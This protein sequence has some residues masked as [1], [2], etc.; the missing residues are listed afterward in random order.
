MAGQGRNADGLGDNPETVNVVRFPGDWFGPLEDLVPIGDDHSWDGADGRDDREAADEEYAYADGFWGEQAEAV[1]RVS[2]SFERPLPTRR[3]PRRALV[4]L[5]GIGLA[6]VAAAIVL[7]S[8]HSPGVHPPKLSRDTVALSSVRSRSAHAVSPTEKPAGRKPVHVRPAG[9][10]V[11]RR[12][13]RSP[14]PARH[15]ARGARH[16]IGT[17]AGSGTPQTQ[18]DRTEVTSTPSDRA[19]NTSATTAL[20]PSPTGLVAPP[21]NSSQP[22]S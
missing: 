11:I 20:T 8:G 15:P 5:V 2:G 22:N 14:H 9:T 7:V 10:R 4:T 16:L 21:P 13:R 12:R 3:R 19:P 1:H 18:L 17:D 6:A